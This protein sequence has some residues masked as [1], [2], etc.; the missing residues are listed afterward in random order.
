MIEFYEER[1]SSTYRSDEKVVMRSKNC[2]QFLDWLAR[3]PSCHQYHYGRFNKERKRKYE[4][5][6]KGK[7]HC[8]FVLFI[9]A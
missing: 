1:M 6:N 9:V 7:N 4:E 5:E 3:N 8:L 2:K